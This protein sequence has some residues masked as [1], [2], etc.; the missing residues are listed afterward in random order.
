MKSLF[1]ALLML[2]TTALAEGSAETTAIDTTNYFLG[3][4]TFGIRYKF[5]EETGLV[6]TA[7]RI[8]EMGS[9]I[10]KFSLSKRY[11]GDQYDLPERDDIHSVTDLASKEPSMKTVLDMPFAFYLI[12]IYPFSSG[13]LSWRD[14]LTEAESKEE[15][16]EMFALASYLL[17]TYNGT[18]KTF[19]LGHW[20]GDWHLLDDYDRNMEPPPER[21]QGMIDWLNIRQKAVDDAKAQ[22]TATNVH[23]YHYTEVN[24]VQK[25][26][27]GEHCLT[28]DVLPHTHVDYVSY[29]SYDTTIPHKGDT[30]KVLHE[31]LNYIE[32]KLPP[33]PGI[34]GKRIFIGEYGFPLQNTASPEL[35]AE[36]SKDVCL[37]ALEWGCPFVLYW[38]MYCNEIKEGKHRGFWLIDDQNRKQPFYFVLQEYYE[39]MKKK[40]TKFRKEH[41]QLP[42]NKKLQGMA[43]E[44]LK[45]AL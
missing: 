34:E 19:L 12:W 9:N 45:Q 32:S 36:Y 8:Q 10:L 26:L 25:A 42:N 15:Y 31:A 43:V 41:D 16:D 30:R 23:L 7:R 1:T 21:I 29:S 40:C 5:T 13:G 28:N 20:E 3:T 24:L 39:Q 18:G 4:Q 22:T 38:E 11:C 17:K 35:Q 6:E 2:S 33:K 14:G 27:K 44:I 37:A